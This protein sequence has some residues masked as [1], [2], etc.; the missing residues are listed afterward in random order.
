MI[1]KTSR[2]PQKNIQLIYSKFQLKLQFTD[3]NQN[4]TNDYHYLLLQGTEHIIHG[5]NLY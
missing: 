2:N 1:K 5:L 4:D 3:N